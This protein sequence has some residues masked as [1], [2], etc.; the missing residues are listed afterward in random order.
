MATE[1]HGTIYNAGDIIPGYVDD[2]IQSM[3]W[4]DDSKT[5]QEY[6]ETSVYSSIWQG[7]GVDI[8]VWMGDEYDDMI[9]NDEVLNDIMQYF[10]LH[11]I[12]IGYDFYIF[13]WESIKSN[14]NI[15]WCGLTSQ[16]K[17][18]VK[19]TITVKDYKSS[20]TN[21]SMAEVYNQLKATCT[22]DKF[23]E[24]ISSPF[25]DDDLYSKYYRPQMYMCEHVVEGIKYYP[26]AE[27]CRI[28]LNKGYVPQGSEWAES[29]NDSYYVDWWMQV[30]QNDKW[31]F[32]LNGV[33]NYNSTNVYADANGVYYDQWKLLDYIQQT[34]FA[35]GII[36]WGHGDK[37]NWTNWNKVENITSFDTYMVIGVNGNGLNPKFNYKWTSETGQDSQSS[38]YQ[39]GTPTPSVNDLQNAN[40]S[41]E[42]HDSTEIDY[43]PTDEDTTNYLI[44]SGKFVLQPFIQKTGT[45]GRYKDTEK[46][47]DIYDDSTNPPRFYMT[48]INYDNYHK[49]REE[50]NTWQDCYNLLY[51]A[52]PVGAMDLNNDSWNQKGH[53]LCY[54]KS[55][56]QGRFVG[57]NDNDEGR[58][59][60]QLYYQQPYSGVNITH[61]QYTAPNKI[62]LSPPVDYGDLFKTYKFEL[63]TKTYY[64]VPKTSTE[65]EQ[66]MQVVPIFECELRIGNKYCVESFDENGD[67][68]Y[69]WLTADE[70]P[71]YQD[72]VSGEYIK[73]STF[74]LGFMP[75]QG[76]YIIG[77]EH[78]FTN[79]IDTSMGLTGKGTG[80]PIKKS[81][82]VSGDITFK[83]VGLVNTYWDDG[84]R[85]HPT[86]FRHTSKSSNPVPILSH[87]R[88][89]LIKNFDVKFESDNGG[90]TVTDDKD[91]VYVSAETNLYVNKKDDIEFRINTALTSEEAYRAGTTTTINKNNIM[92]IDGS[93]ILNFTNKITNEIG[94]GEQH[95][96]DS[97]YREYN[98]PK[99]IIETDVKIDD[100]IN[101]FN[102]YV[103]NYFNGKSFFP[104]RIDYKL[105]DDSVHL[106]VKEI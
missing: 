68:I 13:D 54:S 20:G 32:K 25:E 55:D 23:D 19:K 15:S 44:F 6:D 89:V 57:S 99:L 88:S 2:P 80:I 95:Y 4:W 82:E 21:I 12:Q 61:D 27:F 72:D 78:E 83:I 26:A 105:Y 11:I 58:Y 34:P 47:Y 93:R 60:Q 70:L 101:E 92:S 41:I 30:M 49:L 97:Y 100:D 77:D 102:K 46:L 106:V 50:L 76:K 66:L 9:P 90:Y 51:N 75:D 62:L 22:I 53:V 84:V 1:F 81:D 73:K 86:W 79:N 36:R 5:Y 33:D 17:H 16:A 8:K 28:M 63:G 94:K 67:S 71:T 39:T 45:F 104:M 96:I 74:S 18:P 29:I 91:L 48:K 56:K 43:S 14:N 38:N 85:R 98:E 52:E 31:S 103:F 3:T 7:L 65:M 69:Q 59:Y 35:S 42:Y 37:R 40:M 10:N 87:V 64:G 24:V